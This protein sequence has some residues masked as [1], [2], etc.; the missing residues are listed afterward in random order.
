M[1]SNTIMASLISVI[2]AQLAL[3]G[4]TD[5]DVSQNF[6]PSDQYTGGDKDSEFKTKIF[7]HSITNPNIGRSRK[8]NKSKDKR[9]DIHHKSKVIQ[10]SVVHYFDYSDIDSK[11]PEDMAELVADLLDSPDAIKALRDLDI[12]LQEVG[13]V[14]PVFTV[15]DKD[16]NESVPNFDLVINYQS[17]IIKSS[18]V[19]NNASGEAGMV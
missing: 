18:G 1:N 15:N 3:V 11:T 10:V 5:F 9:A 14:R 6:Q 17:D 4:I 13:E 16:Q 12:Y 2:D 19:V 7:L 8:Y